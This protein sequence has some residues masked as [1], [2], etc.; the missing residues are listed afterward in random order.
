MSPIY[1]FVASRVHPCSAF[2][3]T[4]YPTSAH[5]QLFCI[6]SMRT[7]SEAKQRCVVHALYSHKVHCLNWTKN[8]RL[9]GKV[10]MLKL[11][12]LCLQNLQVGIILP[13]DTPCTCP[14]TLTVCCV[15]KILEAWQQ[16]QPS[17]LVTALSLCPEQQPC[18]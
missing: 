10:L 5:N 11:M 15:L 16:Q 9:G 1:A 3:R 8:S 6:E 18:L 13:H 7:P 2:N 4:L 12:H 17:T 14:Q